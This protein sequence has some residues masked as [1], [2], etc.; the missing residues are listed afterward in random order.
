MFSRF[1]SIGGRRLL[2]YPYSIQDN[3]QYSL[4]TS[5]PVRTGTCPFK[6]TTRDSFDALS[7]C[8]AWQRGFHF[9]KMADSFDALSQCEAWQRGFHF[10][11]MADSAS[12]TNVE[13]YPHAENNHEEPTASTNNPL[14]VNDTG[15]NK[16]ENTSHQSL[17]IESDLNTCE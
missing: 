14:P 16:L 11:K 8:E 1:I 4:I 10:D 15:V 7:Q 12:P 6:Q 3:K 9:D 2:R 13:V 5:A 17:S